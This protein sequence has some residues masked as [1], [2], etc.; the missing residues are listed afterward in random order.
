MSINDVSQ[1][2]CPSCKTGIDLLLWLCPNCGFD[3]GYAA[4][5]KAH[6]KRLL[7]IAIIAVIVYISW[8]FGAFEYTE[9]RPSSPYWQPIFRY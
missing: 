2:K 5:R 4:R 1:K 6:Y 9:Y 8:K 7:V 3:F